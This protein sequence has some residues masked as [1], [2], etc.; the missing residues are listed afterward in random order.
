MSDS[1]VGEI[2]IYAFNFAPAGTAMCNG[3]IL[4]ISQNQ[5]LFALLGTIYGGN[6][7]TNFQ[8]PNLQSRVPLHFGQGTGLSPYTL[9]E[10]AGTENTT[11]LV[12]NL[13]AHNHSFSGALNA[14]QTKASNQQP[15]TG[16]LLGR[17][18][19]EHENDYPIIYCPAGTAGTQV[20]LGGLT[21]QVG[22]TGS[23]L[24]FSIVQPFLALNFCIN[25]RGRFPARN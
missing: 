1:Y 12:N 20:A 22:N 13:P 15:N 5:A 18:T 19:D 14:V 2:R 25:L 23:N 3:Q 10:Q 16:S 21:G 11:L 17:P 24:P 9:G 7:Q 4:A 6:G 8:L